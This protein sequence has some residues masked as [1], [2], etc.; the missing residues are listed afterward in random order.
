MLRDDMAAILPNN[1]RLTNLEIVQSQPRWPYHDKMY[2]LILCVHTP[3]SYFL[4]SSLL[5]ES[6]LTRI[7]NQL[8]T[9]RSRQPILTHGPRGALHLIT[10]LRHTNCER[11]YRV[12]FFASEQSFT[13]FVKSWLTIDYK[14]TRFFNGTWFS[15]AF[16]ILIRMPVLD[17][18][19]HII[20]SC[21]LL[22]T[23]TYC[24]QRPHQPEV[25]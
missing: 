8:N 6:R 1:F 7:T 13:L 24:Y 14:K 17:F 5:L 21:Y 12:F 2:E 16:C 22:G 20:H 25:C 4:F 19:R 10:E 3:C 15:F 11:H 23:L 9:V 18:L